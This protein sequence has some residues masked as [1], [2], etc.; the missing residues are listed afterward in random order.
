M[1]T[2][3]FSVSREDISALFPTLPERSNKGSCGRVLFICGSYDPCG[4]AMS[5]AAYFAAASAYRSGA[6]IVKIFTRRENYVSLSSKLPEA[7]YS[8]YGDDENIDR[9]EKRLSDELRWADAVVIGCGLGKSELSCR[10]V[11]ATLTEVSCPM[12][13]DADALN[14]MAENDALWSCLPKEQRKRTII[15]PHM[16][17]MSR[18]CGNGIAD[19]L[20]SPVSF[21]RNFAGDKGVVCLLKDH[22]TVITDGE[23]VFLNN[24]GNA[25]MASAGMG[26]LLSGIIGAIVSRNTLS[27]SADTERIGENELLYRAAVGAYIHGCAGDVAA[28]KIGEYSLIASDLLRE[29]GGVISA[30]CGDNV[31]KARGRRV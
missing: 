2:E 21:A 12:V 9:I 27:D 7:V 20:L 31:K 18:L 22:K 28:G 15:T 11:K 19:I 30:F 17:E 26:D 10:L 8:L 16:G 1:M 14:I 3:T 5:G 6:G 4:S 23:R 29:I 24:S 25:G 13:I